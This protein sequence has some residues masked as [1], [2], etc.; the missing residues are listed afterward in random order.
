MP[1]FVTSR[2]NA[3]LQAHKDD[4]GG[5][6]FI[7]L[8]TTL[9]DD[10]GNGGVEVATASYARQSILYDTPANGI[11]NNS[12]QIVFPVPLEEGGYGTIVGFGV[13]TDVDP[14]VA[15]NPEAVL[16]IPSG[17]FSMPQ[18]YARTLEPGYLTHQ[19]K[20]SL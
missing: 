15:P 18:G 17:S 19:I 1:G 2:R 20:G 7:G 10:D 5:S 4:N 11:M 9:P 3:W 6:W 13:F 12:N 16:R 8:Y 14:A